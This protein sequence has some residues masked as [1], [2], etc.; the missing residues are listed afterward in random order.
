M[1]TNVLLIIG[2]VGVAALAVWGIFKLKNKAEGDPKKIFLENYEMFKPLAENIL[3]EFS[4][5]KW[6]EAIV[7]LNNKVLIKWWKE[8]VKKHGNSE[9]LVRNDLVA[10]LQE[11]GVSIVNKNQA[12]KAFLSNIQIFVPIL[13]SLND[14]TF[15]AKVWTEYI[16]TVN[17]F[18]LIELWKKYVS[19]EDT[20]N[21]WKRL[22]ASWQVKSDV[23]KSFTCV[24]EDNKAS[25]TL[26]DGS[27]IIEG[28]KYKVEKPCWVYTF[29]KEDGTIVKDILTKGIV[30]PM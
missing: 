20:K 28:V 1:E 11:W 16:V 29:E 14:D 2:G 3:Y 25:Y 12:K 26:K 6:T 4:I 7:D 5:S 23:C 30:T 13:S 21:K 10:V 24:N 18:H 17:D 15:N 9:L 8:L 19:A 22:L 27:A